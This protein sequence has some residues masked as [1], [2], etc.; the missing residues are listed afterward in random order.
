MSR[1]AYVQCMEVHIKT[2]LVE[3]FLG[4]M[5]NPVTTDLATIGG[6]DNYLTNPLLE[7]PF[8]SITES[9]ESY[10]ASVS[11]PS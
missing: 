2:G 5:H 10:L 1:D 7:G 4:D 8:V 6:N 9:G 11:N 3:V